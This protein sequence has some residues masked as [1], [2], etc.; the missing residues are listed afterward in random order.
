MAVIFE[1]I[2]EYD[3]LM[4]NIDSNRIMLRAYNND[5]RCLKS[6]AGKKT[7]H[8]YRMPLFLYKLIEKEITRRK[9]A[10]PRT[11]TDF[12]VTAMY[13]SPKGKNSYRKSL[14]Y[15]Y[16]KTAELVDLVHYQLEKRKTK[17]YQRTLM[18]AS[19]RY[20][21]LLRDGFKCQICGASMKDGATLHVDHIIPVSKGGETEA[22]N[23][24]TLC[25]RCNLGKRDKIES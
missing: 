9:K 5:F 18:S 6:S 20:D 16:G 21:I 15:S 25:D 3:K 2:D 17:D 8:K 12:I 7:V 22:N 13:V 1:N 23:L 4:S 11:D 14:S 10:N 24:R 19:L